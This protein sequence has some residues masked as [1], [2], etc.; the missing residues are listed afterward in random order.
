MRYDFSEFNAY[1]S[2]VL[3]L[4]LDAREA[5]RSLPKFPKGAGFDWSHVSATGTGE[6]VMVAKPNEALL[7]LKVA[8]I[9]GDRD[10]EVSHAAPPG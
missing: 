10:V 2:T 4:I 7:G 1:A 5:G 6:R 9:T 8:L 3:E